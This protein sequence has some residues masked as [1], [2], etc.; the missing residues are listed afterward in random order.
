[1]RKMNPKRLFEMADIHLKM[2]NPEKNTSVLIDLLI[3]YISDKKVQKKY[4]P[5]FQ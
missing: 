2:S 3:N 4:C 5:L 1:M